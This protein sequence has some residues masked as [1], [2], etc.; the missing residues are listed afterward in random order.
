MKKLLLSL[1][2]M[3]FALSATAQSKADEEYAS[4]V[5]KLMELTYVKDNLCVTLG[6]TYASMSS[7]LGLSEEK[8]RELGYVLTE[9][10]YED[11]VELCIPIY[12]QYFTLKDIKAACKFYSSKTGR[13]FGEF[14]P[15]IS[16]EAMKKVDQL[17]PK[18]LSVAQ[19]FIIENYSE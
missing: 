17:L 13:K 11:Y 6:E 9:A 7:Q 12:K 8:A 3:A 4:K 1:V 10:I 14:S 18:V 19:E 16:V 15:Q 2:V 5:K